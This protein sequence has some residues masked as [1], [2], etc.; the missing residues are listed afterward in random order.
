MCDIY[1]VFPQIRVQSGHVCQNI[2]WL[3]YS[4]DIYLYATCFSEPVRKKPPSPA[5]K[6]EGR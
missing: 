6:K 1:T 3:K 4:S 5:E 2:L